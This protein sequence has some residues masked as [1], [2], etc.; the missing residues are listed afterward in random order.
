LGWLW[1]ARMVDRYSATLAWNETDCGCPRTYQ[2]R[3]G[4]GLSLVIIIGSGDERERQSVAIIFNQLKSFSIS[5]NQRS[6]A[7][8]THPDLERVHHAERHRAH[9]GRV[10][11]LPNLEGSSVASQWYSKQRP[12]EAIR[13]HQRP[14]A[15]LT[16]AISM[17]S[18]RP[19]ACTHLVIDRPPVAKGP[20]AK[21][22]VHGMIMRD[23]LVRRVGDQ[24]VRGRDVLVHLPAEV[25]V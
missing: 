22:R 1:A 15:A 10:E 24:Q 16:E 19:S 7:A 3:Q 18:Q 13:G 5:C 6:S 4:K 12:S 21:Q 14:P 20:R 25:R 17:H 11:H 8:I 23:A 2:N 9:F